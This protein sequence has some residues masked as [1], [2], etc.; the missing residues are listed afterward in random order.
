MNTMVLRGGLSAL[1]PMIAV[2]GTIAAQPVADGNNAGAA[3]PSGRVAFRERDYAAALAAAR[4]EDKPLLVCFAAAFSL[5][6]R[7]LDETTWVEPGV[8]KLLA[9]RVVA[10]RVDVER[11]AALATRFRVDRTPTLLLLDTDERELDCI[12]GYR[13]AKLMLDELEGAL[14]GRDAEVRARARIEQTRGQDPVARQVLGNV[15]VRKGR[16]AEALEQF[17]WCFDE[18]L[19]RNIVYASTQR[20]ALF[21]DWARLAERFAPARAAMERR[22]ASCER[23]LLDERDDANVAR[24]LAGLAQHLGETHALV[25]FYDRLKPDSRARGILIDAV[26]D[27]F[28]DTRRYDDI[29]AQIEPRESFRH[30]VRL[31]RAGGGLACCPVH[32][33]RGPATVGSVVERGARLVEALA[34]TKRDADARA[35]SEDVLRFEDTSATRALLV[36]RLERA[37]RRDLAD[38]WRATPGP[39]GSD[40]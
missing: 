11:D 14:A 12:E 16:Q 35:L 34:A 3:P 18:G 6:C 28:V 39:A 22:R 9:G 4:E 27:P 8:Q 21:S 38:H 19:A 7:F 15:L 40:R 26:F 10:I 30:R 37:G 25:E 20:A 2:V 13:T 24:N 23:V 5:P 17:E 33:R 31:A 32:A 36:A 1:V 29:L